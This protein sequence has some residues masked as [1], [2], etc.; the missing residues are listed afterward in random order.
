MEGRSNEGRENDGERH[1]GSH[2]QHLRCGTRGTIGVPG[3]LAVRP[4]LVLNESDMPY[5]RS[6]T[7][8]TWI[9]SPLGCGA[10]WSRSVLVKDAPNRAVPSPVSERATR[11]WYRAPARAGAPGPLTG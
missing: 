6:Y 2:G 3:T 4:P 5:R 10:F 7:N 11:R 8:T 1:G 9:G